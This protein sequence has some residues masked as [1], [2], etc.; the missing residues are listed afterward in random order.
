MMEEKIQKMIEQRQVA[1]FNI[2][3]K[4]ERV[5]KEYPHL[6]F[7]QIL[8]ILGVISYE[9]DYINDVSVVNDPFHEESVTTLMRMKDM[10]K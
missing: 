4:I 6:R 8:A 1:N 7:G 9:H 3:N 5:V 2:L 10:E